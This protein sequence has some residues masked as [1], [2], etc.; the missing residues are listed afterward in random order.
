MVTS[1]PHSPEPS[2]QKYLCNAVR[3]PSF[4]SSGFEATHNA[5]PIWADA[6]LAVVGEFAEVCSFRDV[7][8]AGEGG[9]DAQLPRSDKEDRGWIT[10]MC[11][12]PA[13]TTFHSPRPGSPR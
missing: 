5:D 2:T 12:R 3:V 11:G 9:N 1:A 8:M 6:G 10:T 13:L 4:R 7:V